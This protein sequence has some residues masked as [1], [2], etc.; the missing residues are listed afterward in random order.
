[1]S[2]FPHQWN[3]FMDDTEL[4]II[5]GW[6]VAMMLVRS[7]ERITIQQ[8]F[9]ESFFAVGLYTMK[10]FDSYYINPTNKKRELNRKNNYRRYNSLLYYSALQIFGRWYFFLFKTLV[11]VSLSLFV[12]VFELFQFRFKFNWSFCAH[13][14]NEF[15][16]HKA[17]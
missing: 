10:P 5:N 17:S 13:W 3:L 15:V 1:M 8:T 11:I 12:S 6:I 2:P 7:T 14:E 16:L 4:N 9:S